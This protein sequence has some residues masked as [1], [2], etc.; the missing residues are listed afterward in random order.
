M[1]QSY[2]DL[3]TWRKAM[4]LV[5]NIYRATRAFPREEVYGLTAQLH[6][7][8]ISVPSN[9]AEGQAR[10]SRREFHRFLTTARGSLAE[11]ETQL[12]IASAVGYLGDECVEALLAEAGEIGR[13]LNGLLTSVQ[14]C[15][16]KDSETGHLSTGY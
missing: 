14:S 1:A 15:L 11:V 16:T 6:R 5:T 4:G 12:Q 13:M 9:I 10:H 3:L 8:A 7:A 2:R